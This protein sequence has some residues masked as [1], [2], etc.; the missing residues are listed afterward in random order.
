MATSSSS[1]LQMPFPFPADKLVK[2]QTKADK[3]DE[4]VKLRQSRKARKQASEQKAL[5]SYSGESS[6][7]PKKKK[8]KTPWSGSLDAPTGALL[9]EEASS[10]DDSFVLVSDPGRP[11]P[12]T[13]TFGPEKVSS[14]SSS[15]SATSNVDM[16]DEEDDR[17]WLRQR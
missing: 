12:P 10:G 11:D 5:L 16:S 4:F 9:H 3:S 1:S 14:G 2:V 15:I 7:Q 17:D 8:L 13:G 6:L